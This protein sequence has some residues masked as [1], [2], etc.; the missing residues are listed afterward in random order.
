M[1]E[2][3]IEGYI[4]ALDGNWL[5]VIPFDIAKVKNIIA[6]YGELNYVP[7]LGKD[8]IKVKPGFAEK[9]AKMMGVDLTDFLMQFVG[10]NLE[11]TVSVKKNTFTKDGNKSTSLSLIAKSIKNSCRTST[12]EAII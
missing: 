7:F 11:I 4:C 6:T 1:H 5:I 8:R 9:R 10:Q 2:I 3:I 12:D